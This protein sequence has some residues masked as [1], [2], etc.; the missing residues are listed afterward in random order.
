M[1]RGLA[2]RQRALAL[3]DGRDGSTLL[4]RGGSSHGDDRYVPLYEANMI[5]QFDHR[6]ATFDGDG[7]TDHNAT[8]AQKRD[9]YFE[10]T[11]RYWIS[12]DEVTERLRSKSWTRGWLTGFRDIALRSVERTVIAAALP[13]SGVGH[14]APLF[15]IGGGLGAWAALL[16]N[17]TSLTL[18]FTARLKVGGTHLTYSYLKQFPVLH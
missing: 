16:G 1:M 18:D 4:P 6:W 9:P 2:V 5:H 17:L 15:F 12:D 3:V 13:R 10:P 8:L 14:T 11:P 7:E